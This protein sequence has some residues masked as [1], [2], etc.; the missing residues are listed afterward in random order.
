MTPRIVCFLDI[1]VSSSERRGWSL[2]FSLPVLGNKT[3]QFRG[4]ITLA[5]RRGVGI[6]V[7]LGHNVCHFHSSVSDSAA[8]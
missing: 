6:M 4:L 5:P 1:L 7:G 3:Q 8:F 2:S